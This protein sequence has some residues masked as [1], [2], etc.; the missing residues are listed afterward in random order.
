MPSGYNTFG[1]NKQLTTTDL[2]KSFVACA[3]IGIPQ[4]RSPKQI[5]D[6]CQIHSEDLLQDESHLPILI[7]IATLCNGH[8][9]WPLFLNM[10]LF[11]EKRSRAMFE[12]KKRLTDPC[13]VVNCSPRCTL[14][15]YYHRILSERST[16]KTFLGKSSSP[17]SEELE[18]KDTIYREERCM[19]F[20][21]L[22]ETSL[23]R[24]Q[25]QLGS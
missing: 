22:D 13:K 11:F 15:I 18:V 1:K 12:F 24:L 3:M 20:A 10:A 7:W 14:A 25:L 16:L 8:F 17:E 21:I 6:T 5:Q 19:L 2:M 9:A 4:K 23:E